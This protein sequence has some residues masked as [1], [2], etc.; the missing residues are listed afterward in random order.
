MWSRNEGESEMSK[1]SEKKTVGKAGKPVDAGKLEAVKKARCEAGR[2]G[3]E[4][5]WGKHG[6]TKSVRAFLADAE[7][8]EG[9]APT[10]A[11]AVRMVFEA[12]DGAGVEI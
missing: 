5:R 2:R 7:R 10:T 12:L 6:K 1:V 11:E 3:M 4:A 8:L 9:M